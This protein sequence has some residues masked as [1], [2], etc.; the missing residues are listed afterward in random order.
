MVSI[1]LDLSRD[2]ELLGVLQERLTKLGIHSEVREHLLTLVV[3]RGTRLPVCVFISGNGR[4]YS[5]DSTR[6][7]VGDVERAA[8]QLARIAV[9]T[10]PQRHASDEGK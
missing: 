7:H 8:A 9:R 10:G 4:F 3:F 5:W 6:E 1:A 2:L